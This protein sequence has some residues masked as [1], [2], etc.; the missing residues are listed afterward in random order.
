[1]FKR[2]VSILI[3]IACLPATLFAQAAAPSTSYDRPVSWRYASEQ[4]W[5]VS[6]VVAT[7][8]ELA[9]TAR[10]TPVGNIR[11]TTLQ[12]AG[13][14]PRFVVDASGEQTTIEIR[15]HLWAPANYLPLVKKWAAARPRAGA[16][17]RPSDILSALTAPRIDVLESS[18]REIG[19]RLSAKSPSRNDYD[20]AALLLGVMGL[21]EGPT[22]GD[23]R[24]F[25]SRMTAHLAMAQALSA[26]PTPSGRVAELLQLALVERQRDV[27]D[28]LE[29]WEAA[30]PSPLDRSWI[31]ALRV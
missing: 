1:M 14:V 7:L 3:C 17:A 8:A 23:V 22:Y 26:T 12:G 13:P 9:D 19:R 2:P 15:D 30:S 5:I 31:L 25:L 20:D 21:R 24:P 10:K 18:N 28:R 11:V 4:E 16:A 27:L 29:K 6:S